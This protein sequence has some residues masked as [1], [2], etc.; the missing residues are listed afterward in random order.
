M[1]FFAMSISPIGVVFVL[2]GVLLLFGFFA[3]YK[4][5]Q[6]R[7]FIAPSIPR[8]VRLDI[9]G[10]VLLKDMLKALTPPYALE[11][12]I[13]QLGSEMRYYLIVSEKY[14]ERTKQILPVPGETVQDYE[15][16]S[17]DGVHHVFS[18]ERSEPASSY[19]FSEAIEALRDIDLSAVNEI[20]E[21]VVMQWVVRSVDDK[22][23]LCNG[24]L[25]ISAPV[26]TQAKEII[27][28]MQCSL[29]EGFTITEE[30]EGDYLYELT[31]RKFNEENSLT[32][33]K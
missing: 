5:L 30:T 32:F 7:F 18:L 28:K 16:Y 10:D 20:G 12:A 31:F 3:F 2:L 9:T 24:R 25:L 19:R 8:V 6:Y 23:Y 11:I 22:G 26:E 21:S 27:E 29:P 1:D 17:M 13:E 4:T 33:T 15:I 14:V